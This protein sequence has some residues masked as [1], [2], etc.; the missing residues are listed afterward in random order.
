MR[1]LAFIIVPIFV[2]SCSSSPKVESGDTGALPLAAEESKSDMVGSQPEDQIIDNGQTKELPPKEEKPDPFADLKDAE[3]SGA[4]NLSA[5][6]AE[7]PEAE[8]TDSSGGMSTY[9]VKK[10]DTL[11]KIAFSLYGDL[12]KW[13]DLKE[14]N[15]AKL[16][17]AN[18][19]SPGMSLQYETP[20][21]AFNV[22]QLGHSYTIKKGDTLANIADDVYGR[23]IKY[24]KLQKYNAHLIKNPN[25]IFAGFTLFYDITEQEMAEADARRQEKRAQASTGTP[26]PEAQPIAND[27]NAAPAVDPNAPAVVAPDQQPAQQVATDQV[28]P[29]PENAVP[30]AVTGPGVEAAQAQDIAVQTTTPDGGAT[31]APAST[32]PQPATSGAQ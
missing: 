18:A 8:K 2:F 19:L 31:T 1:F 28:A 32:T 20:L 16:K 23:K 6:A 22:E 15:S 3:E 30:S 29:A 24:K 17:N 11:M 27:P 26:T 10:G 7:A 12:D 21:E 13:K 14:W 5:S 9:T 25:R 4:N